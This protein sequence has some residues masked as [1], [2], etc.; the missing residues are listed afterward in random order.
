MDNLFLGNLDF[1]KIIVKCY[2]VKGVNILF[3]EIIIIVGVLEVLNL[4]L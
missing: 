3:D 4:S 2:V 1:R